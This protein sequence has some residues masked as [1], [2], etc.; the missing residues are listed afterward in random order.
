MQFSADALDKPHDGAISKARKSFNLSRF[1]IR[2]IIA[3]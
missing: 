1:M 2:C 3:Y